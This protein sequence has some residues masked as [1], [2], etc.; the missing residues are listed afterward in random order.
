VG[1]VHP[2]F[3][4]NGHTLHDGSFLVDRPV[5]G[6]VRREVMISGLVGPL[7]YYVRTPL[8]YYN[9]AVRSRW[10]LVHF[11]DHFIDLDRYRLEAGAEW[12]STQ[13][14]DLVPLFTFFVCRKPYGATGW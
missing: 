4:T 8:D 1:L 10:Q 13:R 12:P 6:S 3:H 5:G 11:R 14:T 2:Y 7:T 9:A